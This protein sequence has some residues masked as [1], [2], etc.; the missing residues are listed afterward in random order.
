MKFTYLG[1][2][3]NI[4]T[5]IVSHQGRAPY[6]FIDVTGNKVIIGDEAVISSGV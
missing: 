2:P 5:G 4:V 1:D 3:T 6:P